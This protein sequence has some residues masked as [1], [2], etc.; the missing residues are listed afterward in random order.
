MR[1]RKTIDSHSLSL[2]EVLRKPFSYKV[3]YFQRDYAW[4]DEEVDTLWED[5]KRA[6]LDQDASDYFLG[7]IVVAPAEDDKNRYIVDGQQRLATLSM[8]FSAISHEWAETGDTKRA[9]GVKRDYL[10]QEDRRTGEIIPKLSLNETNDAVFQS[11]VLRGEQPTKPEMKNWHQ[12]DRKIFQ[13]FTKL[14]NSVAEWLT[15]FD[16]K[17]SALVD[18]EDFLADRLNLI[19]I[20]VADDADAFVIFETL[21]DRGLELAVSDLVKNFLFSQ[22]GPHIDK[23]KLQWQDISLLVGSSNLTQFLR[24][25]WLC[26]VGLVRERD[27]YRELRRTVKN[28][29]TARRFIEQLRA[30]AD[31]YA[32]L[33]NPE[34]EYWADFPR[35]ATDH[36]QALLI[37]GVTQYRPVMLAAMQKFPAAKAAKILQQLMVISFRYTVVSALGTGNLE[38]IYADAALAI[39]NE[40]ATSPQEAFARLTN[41]YVDDERFVKDFEARRYR[42]S[43]VARYILAEINNHLER[44]SEKLVSPTIQNVLSDAA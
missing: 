21:N 40:T 28:K 39:Q 9:E 43:A 26:T 12:A 2:G 33:S 24:H 42:K 13:A 11:V 38:K 17:D 20:E 32:A 1:Q 27:L 19:A 3:P 44:S 25:Y 22:A 36:L 34:H 30:A 41:A 15:K 5:I 29:T 14:K 18:L 37:F 4:S 7:A 8:L 16:D 10:G 6:L 31:F 35:K 23:F